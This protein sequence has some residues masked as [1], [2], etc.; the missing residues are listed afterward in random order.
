MSEEKA[1]VS[2]QP[3]EELEGYYDVY[4]ARMRGDKTISD[5]AYRFYGLLVNL[6]RK[7]G[8]AWADN[9][10]LCQQTGIAERTIQGY[11]RQL[12][13]GDYIIRD[14]AENG[15]RRIWIYSVYCAEFCTPRKNLRGRGAEICGANN[16]KN[17][18]KTNNTPYNPPAVDVTERRKT[19]SEIKADRDL[20]F[21]KIYE[22]YPRHEDPGSARR[23]FHRLKPDRDLAISIYKAIKRQKCSDDWTKECGKYVPKLHNW[24]KAESWK[25]EPMK[26]RQAAYEEPEER[27]YELV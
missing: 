15:R 20:W 7:S 25:N 2:G 16:R 9:N 1:T 4:P 19:A 6:A 3:P 26:S 23:E 8:F 21:D 27:E 24:L 22:E 12:E 18:N 10:Y 5:G 14:T 11:L 17:N 13:D